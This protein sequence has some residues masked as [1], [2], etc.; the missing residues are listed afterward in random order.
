[1]RGEAANVPMATEVP[2]TLAR[3]SVLLSEF[4]IL[5]HGGA[6]VER[7]QPDLLR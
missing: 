3:R 2:R 7:P 6:D 4:V 5:R 1:M